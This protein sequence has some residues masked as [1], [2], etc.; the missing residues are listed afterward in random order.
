[1]KTFI[2]ILIQL[3][4]FNNLMS[5]LFT[6]TSDTICR[7]TSVDMRNVHSGLKSYTWTTSE[8][9]IRTGINP[10]DVIFS[11]TGSKSLQLEI[12]TYEGTVFADSLTLLKH[13]PYFSITD[14][15]PD[16]YYRIKDKNGIYIF[17]SRVMSNMKVPGKIPGFI[18]LDSTESYL[19]EFW[20]YDIFD[21]D[22]FLGSIFVINPSGEREYQWGDVRMFLKCRPAQEKYT[23]SKSI[24]V[25]DPVIEQQ[26]S[27]LLVTHAGVRPVSGFIHWKKD[28]LTILTSINPTAFLPPDDGCYTATY[29]R[30]GTCNNI[31]SEPYCYIKTSASDIIED[32]INIPGLL[33]AGN[34]YVVENSD[35]VGKLHNLSG[36]YIQTFTNVFQPDLIPSGVYFLLWENGNKVF[37]KKVIIIHQ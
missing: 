22:D 11:E 1:M 19:F 25:A 14:P 2:I 33:I 34:Q 32:G 37:S 8:G 18:L 31:T 6:V 36:H 15:E 13:E 30:S 35:W 29:Q 9:L 20:D 28:N 17:T 5:Q 12:E 21:G 23:Y 16:I 10:N 4:I 7:N 26:D 24:T 3:M 27:V